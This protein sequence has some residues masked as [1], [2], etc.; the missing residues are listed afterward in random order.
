MDLP[1]T[2]SNTKPYEVKIIEPCPHCG[3]PLVG[4]YE[5]DTNAVV[6]IYCKNCLRAE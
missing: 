5:P 4:T 6:D 3:A 2:L 1:T